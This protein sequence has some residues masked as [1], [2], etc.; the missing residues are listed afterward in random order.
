MNERLMDYIRL[1]H[2]IVIDELTAICIISVNT[3]NLCRS[4]ENIIGLFILEE[5]RNLCLVAEIEL[6]R[7][8]YNEIIE[9]K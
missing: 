6:P 2:E 9:A 3:T 7:I 4:Q 1:D 5:S 8:A